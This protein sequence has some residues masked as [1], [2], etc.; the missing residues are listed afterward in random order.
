M[1]LT[2][3]TAIA[4]AA[5]L[6]VTACG[7]GGSSTNSSSTPSGTALLNSDDTPS[8]GNVVV[9]PNGR[10]LY[11]FRKDTGSTSTCSGAC[12]EAWPPLTTDGSI[13][14]SG[15]VSP[16]L[17][18]TVRRSDGKTQ[19]T[20]DGHPLYYYGGDGAA[21][22]TNGQGL[23]AFGALWYALSPS[24]QEITSGGGGSSSGY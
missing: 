1:R 21:G 16:G 15:G 11:I 2:M 23:N 7:G 6:F 13:T 24:G 5:A 17:V 22:Q 12:A 19:V 8:L 4:V 3:F 14:T 9:G 10:T 20:L 18:K